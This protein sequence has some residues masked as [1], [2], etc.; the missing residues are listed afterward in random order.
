MIKRQYG[1][2]PWSSLKEELCWISKMESS[3]M[4]L[5]FSVTGV[6]LITNVTEVSRLISGS[7]AKYG[8]FESSSITMDDRAGWRSMTVANAENTAALRSADLK[9]WHA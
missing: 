5:P 3:S 7:L 1:R 4:S 6:C 2:A 8:S 9:V